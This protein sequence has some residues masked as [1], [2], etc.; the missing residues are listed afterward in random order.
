MHPAC[1]RLVLLAL[2]TLV[3]AL[4]RFSATSFGLPDK[5]RPDEGYLV[6]RAL[7]FEHDWNPR[8]AVYPAAQMYLQHG[9][10]R[11]YAKL[12]APGA[13]DFREVYAPDGGALA[14]LLGRRLSAAFGAATVPAIYLVASS[15]YG[16]V[17]G[18]TAAA[19]VALSPIHV[20][21][22][23]Y[24]TTDAALVFWLTLA[25]G[26]ILALTRRG[27]YRDYL[28]AGALAGLATATKYPAAT[29]LVGIVI[30][31]LE[32]CHREGRS[33]ARALID[34]RI[35]AAL[36]L[37]AL[38]FLCATP[39]FVLDWQSTLESFRYQ[40]AFV[41]GG[42]GNADAGYGWSW[43][44]LHALPD[45]FGL[46]CSLLFAAAL[47]WA[48]ARPGSGALALAGFVLLSFLGMTLSRYVFYRYI[49][50]A[51]P[52]LAILAG[53]MVS[54]LLA[55]AE[56]RDVPQGRSVIAIVLGLVVL[57]GPATARNLMLIRLLDR[58][59]TRTVARKWIAA[60]V[61]RGS[62][63][64]VSDAAKRFG[65]PQ[66]SGEYQLVPLEPLASLRA[67][68]VEWVFADTSPLRFFS[69]GPDAAEL[70]ELERDAKLRLDVDPVRPDAPAPVFD[71]ADAFYAPLRNIGSM[72]RPGPRVRI[73][74]IDS[75][76]RIEDRR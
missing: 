20:R 25:L 29:V 68:R 56:R 31:H 40:R 11:L 33:I 72:S 12:A 34:P 75:G 10:L 71:A 73:W 8:F 32:G 2:L 48:L 47:F 54:D 19:L 16:P 14:Y 36:A 63:I 66:L 61:P 9:L 5:Y 27:R 21:E 60:N 58:E 15:G 74:Q 4:L 51:L 64:A 43:L 6:L 42:G 45:G 41:L 67:K 30:G 26:A 28:A 55:L 3:A 35:Y 69:P 44:L 52:A 24:A 46:G 53:A 37:A 59:D 7:D 39:Y 22:S 13:R 23:R 70:S 17:A 1:R 18:F 65:K 38:V 76:Q 49:L 57:L 50:V 62:S